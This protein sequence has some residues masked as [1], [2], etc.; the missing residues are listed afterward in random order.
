MALITN[1]KYIVIPTNKGDLAFTVYFIDEPVIAGNSIYVTKWDDDTYWYPL[2]AWH[3]TYSFN[4]VHTEFTAEANNIKG[5][6][7]NGTY[8]IN[9]YNENNERILH[10]SAG[11]TSN[12]A[13]IITYMFI[14]GT[15]G[16]PY[17]TN[18]VYG[19]QVTLPDVVHTPNTT[20]AFGQINRV[21]WS[22]PGGANFGSVTQA[23]IDLA[24]AILNGSNWDKNDPFGDGGYSDTGGG[25]GDFNGDTD[26]VRHPTPPGLSAVDTGFITL[27]NP[28]TSQLQALAQYMWDN[29]LFDLSN[30]KK[31]FADPMQA[32]LGL[33]VVPVYVPSAGSTNVRVG[34]I[35]TNVVMNLASTQYVTVNCGTINVNEYWGAYLDYSP[36]TKVEIYLPFIGMRPL[37]IDDIMGRAIN[38][39]YVIDI[40]SG[41]CVAT[42]E[43]DADVL[44][45]F[46]GQ[47]GA[48][49][50][51]TGND[52][53]NVINGVMGVA[54]S[55]GGLMMA[56]STL[57][58]LPIDKMTAGGIMGTQIS[59][60]TGGLSNTAQNVNNSKPIPERSGAMAG[61]GGMLGI[62]TPYLIL[63]RPRQ[64]VPDYQNTYTGYPSFITRGLSQ[65]SGFTIVNSIH[66]QNVPATDEELTEIET[67]LKTGV[68]L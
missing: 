61:M 28:T 13:S 54:S 35:T 30:W 15:N 12:T 63:T 46:V 42:L 56:G 51:I 43:C 49:V 44:Y 22:L 68:M 57:S 65:L 59:G 40:L 21:T 8:Y 14:I 19:L 16:V 50:P 29:P 2:A 3:S 31:L 27:F 20:N 33:S 55:I 60:V 38:L 17:V 41:A 45:S 39:Q 1:S 11:G 25:G 18:P 26:H 64:C 24:Y 62:M 4:G 52:W 6:I 7:S 34:N 47:C 37:N 10:Q 32:I 48:S 23:R 67:L 36:Y 9:V 66:L 5:E 53:T 58:S